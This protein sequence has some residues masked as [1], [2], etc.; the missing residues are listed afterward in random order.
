MTFGR[1]QGE[2]NADGD[3]QFCLLHGIRTLALHGAIKSAKDRTELVDLFNS[4]MS[5][6]AASPIQV[7]VM[8]FQEY[9]TVI[10]A[11]SV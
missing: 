3:F 11:C 6:R 9:D 8:S 1:V 4:D 5:E 10:K 2:T 7:L